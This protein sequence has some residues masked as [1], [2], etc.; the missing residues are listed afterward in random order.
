MCCVTNTGT[1]GGCPAPG[2]ARTAPAARRSSSRS[3]MQSRPEQ[4][5]HVAQLDRAGGK[6]RGLRSRRPGACRG[7]GRGARRRG[8]QPFTLAT[9]SRRSPSAELIS[10]VERRLR[11]VVRRAGAQRRH[12]DRGAP[13]VS[14]EATITCD[15]AAGAAAAAAAPSCRPSPASRCRAPPRRARLPALRRAPRSPL[16][17]G[18]AGD[19]PDR[20]VGVQHAR[21]RRDTCSRPRCRRRASTRTPHRRSFSLTPAAAANGPRGVASDQSDLAELVARG[22]RCRTAS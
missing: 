20:R 11:D 2:T 19:D 4:G 10:P 15:A 22:S 17:V 6:R 7:A 9:S 18:G 21:Q 14:V 8:A 16:P 1:C 3:P 5:R 13:L 12:A